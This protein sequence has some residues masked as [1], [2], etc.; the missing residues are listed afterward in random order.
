[1]AWP[2]AV[3]RLQDIDLEFQRINRRLVEIK[4]ELQDEAEL[5]IAQQELEQRA[6]AASIARR[7][8]KDFE[9]K[10]GQVQA[11]LGRTEDKLYG[12]RITNSRELQDLQLEFESLKRRKAMLEDDLLEK[13]MV[14]EDAADAAAVAASRL[15][16]VQAAREQLK[17]SLVAERVQLRSHGQMLLGEAAELKVQIP[18]QV[19]ASYYYLKERTGG[20]P[21][22]RIKDGVCLR[23]GM[24]ILT[25]V[26]RKAEHGEEAY[27]NGCNRLLVV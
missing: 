16:A 3:L 17:Q 23:C 1:M 8:R 26:R 21:V 4:I 9:F 20:V 25:V 18:E 6:A 24:E 12:G 7:A 19:M 2:T 14:S 10:L 13:M 11:K 5:V 27:C 15:V 22:A